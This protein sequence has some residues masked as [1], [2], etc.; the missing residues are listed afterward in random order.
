MEDVRKLLQEVKEKYET[1]KLLEK[2]C[3]FSLKEKKACHTSYSE[4]YRDWYNSAYRLM[5][6]IFNYHED[7]EHFRSARKDSDG[8]VAVLHNNF[9]IIEGSYLSIM[10][11]IEKKLAQ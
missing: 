3:D 7:M 5:E 4:A 6:Q 1:I 2:S 8:N 11:K 10:D 9:S